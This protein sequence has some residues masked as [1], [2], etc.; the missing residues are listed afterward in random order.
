MNKLVARLI[1]IIVCYLLFAVNP[2]QAAIKKSDLTTVNDK[3]AYIIGY[4]LGQQFHKAKLYLNPDIIREG[5]LNGNMATPSLFTHEEEQTVMGT[6]Q[7]TFANDMKTQL[8]Q[9][10]SKNS[11]ASLAYMKTVAAM[12]G[13]KSLVKG[14]LYYKVIKMGKGPT[15]KATDTVK[16]DYEGKLISGKT[17]DSSYQRGIPAT[18][19]LTGVIQGWTKV[20]EVMPVDSTWQVY[21]APGLA[22]GENGPPMIGPNQA[23]IFKIHL[24]DIEKKK[25]IKS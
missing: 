25:P 21:I 18:F 22:Y 17:F 4:Q 2:L 3:A 6:F 13:V 9:A 16:V 7:Q 20:L 5:F 15:P 14:Q 23:L 10:A 8:H 11:Q 19:P 12:P 24:I 1:S